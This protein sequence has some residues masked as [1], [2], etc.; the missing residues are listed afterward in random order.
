MWLPGENSQRVIAFKS[1]PLHLG[2]VARYAIVFP[3]REVPTIM[4]IISECQ[5]SALP[6]LGVHG[7]VEVRWSGTQYSS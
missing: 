6:S 7:L 5:T 1:A 3:F 4:A 2:H